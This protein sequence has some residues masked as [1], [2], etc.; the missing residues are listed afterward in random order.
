M[1]QRI[2]IVLFGLL[3][4][5]GCKDTDNASKWAGTYITA[6][7]GLYPNSFYRVVVGENNLTSIRIEADSSAAPSQ[8]PNVIYFVLQNVTV[9]NATGTNFSENDSVVGFLHP[10][11]LSGTATLNGAAITLQ[12]TGVNAYDTIHYY[13]YGVKI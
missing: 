3:L 4:F 11:Q 9:Q 12:G 1:V 13:F 5:A 10:F 7:G 8:S 2:L 6:A